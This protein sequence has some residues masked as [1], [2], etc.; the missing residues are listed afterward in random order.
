MLS[1]ISNLCSDPVP[2]IFLIAHAALSDIAFHTFLWAVVS[3]KRRDLWV[4]ASMIDLRWHCCFSWSN[5]VFQNCGIS[6]EIDFRGRERS[7]PRTVGIILSWSSSCIYHACFK[8]LHSS[9][10]FCLGFCFAF[11]Q[12]GYKP[13]QRKECW[14]QPNS[15]LFHHAFVTEKMLK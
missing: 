13:W 11:L 7:P 4:A 15:S 12:A 10:G 5:W 3:C 1:I 2:S 14:H 9:T 8:A 6:T